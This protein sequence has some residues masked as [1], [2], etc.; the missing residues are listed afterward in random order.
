MFI[1]ILSY[2]SFFLSL[3][4]ILKNFPCVLKRRRTHLSVRWRYSQTAAGKSFV[5]VNGMKQMKIQP[6]WPWATMT[7]ASLL[8]T[9][10]TQNVAM[11]QRCPPT[12][13]VPFRPDVKTTWKINNKFAKVIMNCTHLISA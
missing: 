6:A 3:L 11:L 9:H 8:I 10:G 7:T 12:T 1:F 4:N 2:Q 13:T 5:P